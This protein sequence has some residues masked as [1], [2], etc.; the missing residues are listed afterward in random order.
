MLFD[1]PT[2]L[3][4][5]VF[6]NFKSLFIYT[7]KT[8][9]DLMVCRSRGLDCVH[10]SFVIYVYDMGNLLYLTF[11]PHCLLRSGTIFHIFSTL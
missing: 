7:K 11:P 8:E 6:K 5:F 3:S 10:G 9:V 2:V 1:T 4:V